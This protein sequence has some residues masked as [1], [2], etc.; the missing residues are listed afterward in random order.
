MAE[1]ILNIEYHVKILLIKALNRHET[2]EQAAAALGMTYRNLR[3]LLKSYNVVKDRINGR[4]YID[5]SKMKV[6]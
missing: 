5:E 4:F 6:A 3:Y 1:E 2:H